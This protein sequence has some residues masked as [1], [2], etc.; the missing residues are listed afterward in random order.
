MFVVHLLTKFHIQW[1]IS[2]CHSTKIKEN[3]GMFAMLLFCILKH[4]CNESCIVFEHF[5]PYIIL[6][7]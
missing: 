6:G 1:F 3:I 7:S 4:Y 2:Y 5:L